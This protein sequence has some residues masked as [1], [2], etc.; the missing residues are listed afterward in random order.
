MVCTRDT[1]IL[2]VAL[3]LRRWPPIWKA[4]SGSVVLITSRD[5]ARIGY[6]RAGMAAR[7]WGKVDASQENN[8]QYDETK[9]NWTRV[10]VAGLSKAVRIALE[11]VL[12]M[13]DDQYH[14]T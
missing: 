9:P 7:S 8:R 2:D 13:A 10:K 6:L 1:G 5:G 12:V 3:E 4:A 11:D 14:M